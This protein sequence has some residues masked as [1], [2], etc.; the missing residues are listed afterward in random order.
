MPNTNF[1]G[2]YDRIFA[3]QTLC[4][5]HGSSAP[6]PLRAKRLAGSIQQARHKN[7][8]FACLNNF[9][10]GYI[11]RRRRKAARRGVSTD[12]RTCALLQYLYIFVAIYTL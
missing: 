5:E 1:Q 11:I 3:W 4:A 8:Y 12:S 7:F 6:P 2:A 10:G 9:Y